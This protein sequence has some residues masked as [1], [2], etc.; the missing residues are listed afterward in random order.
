MRK[1]YSLELPA[2]FDL[3]RQNITEIVRAGMAEAEYTRWLNMG[4]R[5]TPEQT[6]RQV[7]GKFELSS[8][9]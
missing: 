3:I 1:T 5:N 6:I 9:L 7:M 4:L 8:S 2:A